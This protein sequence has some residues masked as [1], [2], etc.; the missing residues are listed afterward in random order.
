MLNSIYNSK[1]LIVA[2]WPWFYSSWPKIF[3]FK[4]TW[5]KTKKKCPTYREDDVGVAFVET[6]ILLPWNSHYF[7]VLKLQHTLCN[8]Q[9]ILLKKLLMIIFRLNIW[10]Q[11][12]VLM[13]HCT[14]WIQLQTVI[15]YLYPPY[16]EPRPAFLDTSKCWIYVHCVQVSTFPNKPITEKGIKHQKYRTVISPSLHDP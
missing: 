9:I 14:Q 3:F 2:Y 7:H 1:Q 8:L 4:N 10:C 13:K 15:T 12:K 16:I 11:I 5:R 6:A